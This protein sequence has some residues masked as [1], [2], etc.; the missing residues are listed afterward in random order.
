MV[1]A[2]Q[3]VIGGLE[4]VK[5]FSELND[6]LDQRERFLEQERNRAAGDQEA[7]PSDEAFLEA[8]EYGMPPAGGVGLSIDRLTMLLTDVKNIREAILF[9]TLRPK[10]D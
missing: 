4:L 2:F 1:D 3:L 10:T 6:P 5:A 8:L 7:Q 9:P